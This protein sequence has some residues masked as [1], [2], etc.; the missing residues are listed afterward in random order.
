[1]HLRI[2]AFNLST[3]ERCASHPGRFG[4]KD[5]WREREVFNPE[6]KDRAVPLASKWLQ[7]YDY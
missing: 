2:V 1:M 5:G 3:V 4:D 6:A 7:K